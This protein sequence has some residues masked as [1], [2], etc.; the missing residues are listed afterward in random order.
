MTSF[1]FVWSNVGPI[2]DLL[3]INEFSV[4]FFIQI[5]TRNI[6]F[7]INS[8]GGGRKIWVWV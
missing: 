5:Q 6:D 4:W 2:A 3:V 8:S 7:F 1:W